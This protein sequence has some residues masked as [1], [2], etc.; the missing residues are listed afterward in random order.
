[1]ADKKETIVSK[2]KETKPEKKKEKKTSIFKRIAKWFRDIKIE[3]GKITWP[4]ALTTAKNTIVV[5]VMVLVIGSYIW[6]VDL[7]LG[8]GI[9]LIRNIFA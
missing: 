4:T 9:N 8:Y 7:I 5:I 2:A 3:I 6:I 1:M